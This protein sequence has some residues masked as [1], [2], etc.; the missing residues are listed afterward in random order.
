MYYGDVHVK[1]MSKFFDISKYDFFWLREH[2]HL[3]AELNFRKYSLSN[4]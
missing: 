3:G 2:S 1:K 4:H